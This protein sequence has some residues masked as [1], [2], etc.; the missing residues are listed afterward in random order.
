MHSRVL[1]IQILL[2]S[3]LAIGQ[4]GHV[5]REYVQLLL[6]IDSH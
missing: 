3:A 4:I 1:F 2:R 5:S 6:K